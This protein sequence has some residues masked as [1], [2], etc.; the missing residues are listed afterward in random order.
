[1]L[2][3]ASAEFLDLCRMQMAMLVQNLGASLIEIYLTEDPTGAGEASLVP[4][5]LYPEE[6]A[7]KAVQL[8]ALK[9]Q[10]L[11]GKSGPDITNAAAALPPNQAALTIANALSQEITASTETAPDPIQPANLTRVGDLQEPSQMV[12]PLMHENLIWG[13]LVAGRD[14]R[15]W[16]KREKNQLKHTANTLAIA[17]VMDQRA[18]FLAQRQDQH[19]QLQGQNYDTFSML[20]HQVRNPLTTLRTLGKLLL[21]RLQPEDANRSL[22]ETIVEESHHLDGL[23]QQFDQAIDLGEASLEHPEEQDSPKITPLALL[24]SG[25][26]NLQPCWLAEVLYPILS[27]IAGRLDEQQIQVTLNIPAELPAVQADPAALRE[28]FGNLI[29]NAVKYTAAGGG[30][31]IS[32]LQSVDAAQKSVQITRISDT[33][34]GIPPE[35]LE[36][37]FVGHYRGIQAQTDI[38]GTGLGLAIAQ[39]LLMQMGGTIQALSPATEQPPALAPE[40]Q[41]VGSTFVVTLLEQ[42]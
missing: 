16:T 29:D 41:G 2:L 4:L 38:P 42:G 26:L 36:Q 32:I 18:Q 40:A 5:V 35:D 33:G 37:I 14:G 15:R 24:P 23:L 31:Q 22:V 7:Q 28:I 30:L 12:L 25:K 13:I 39:Q 8:P 17:C 6:L 21:K 34:F 1:M 3:P 20:L 10:S 27:A 9:G 19:R 11:Q